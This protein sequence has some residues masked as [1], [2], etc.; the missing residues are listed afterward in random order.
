[1]APAP[2]GTKVIGETTPVNI[3]RRLSVWQTVLKREDGKSIA[4]ITQ[5]Q[6]VL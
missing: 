6:M 1:M 4:L 5:S 2:E 3:G